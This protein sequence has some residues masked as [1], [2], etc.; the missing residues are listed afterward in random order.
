MVALTGW[1]KARCDPRGDA[2]DAQD[3]RPARHGER[4]SHVLV[5]YKRDDEVRVARLV[6]ALQSHGLEVWWD[7]SLPGGEA[8]RD[9]I[10]TA[11][12]SAGCVVVVWTQASV[13]PD[14]GFV[15]DEAGRAKARD[16]LV[17]VRLDNV[18]PPLGFGELQAIDLRRWKTSAKDPFLLDLVAACKAKL[19]SR[20]APAGKGPAARLFR[21]ARLGSL[22]SAALAAIWF[23]ATNSGGVQN[24]ICTIPGPQPLLSDACGVVGVGGRPSR[25]ERLAWAART[26]GS[27]ADLRALITRFPNGVYR[28][29]AADLLAAATSVRA[30]AYSASP[31]TARGYVRQS[32][33]AFASAAAAQ[34]NARTRAQTD[35]VQLCAPRDGDER[36]AGVDVAPLAFDC[37]AGFEGGQVCALDYSATCRIESRALV[38]QC[39]G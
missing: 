27:C 22:V 17:P 25:D 7:Q 39:P 38:E 12:E 6:R 32:E 10:N 30:A 14:G 35:A 21:R 2:L 31:R 34:T 29:K 18:A 1:A 33:H 19:E 24:R 13:G 16:L 9:Q 8:W 26:R 4:M 37:R 28:S 15:R 36:L 23:V 5:S 20:P 3:I 11:L